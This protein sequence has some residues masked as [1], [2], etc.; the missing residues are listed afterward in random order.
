[1][2]LQSPNILVTTAYSDLLFYLIVGVPPLRFLLPFYFTLSFTHLYLIICK[3]LNKNL[4]NISFINFLVIIYIFFLMRFTKIAL[5]IQKSF[6]TKRLILEKVNT[7]LRFIYTIIFS[8]MTRSLNHF[9]MEY[10]LKLY[11]IKFYHAW[12]QYYKIFTLLNIL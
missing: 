3:V 8:I 10:L 6:R 7:D 1:M 12:I 4:G 11:I 2:N 5:Y 9:Q